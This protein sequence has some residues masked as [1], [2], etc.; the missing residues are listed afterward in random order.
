MDGVRGFGRGLRGFWED[1]T[2][3]TDGWLNTGVSTEKFCPPVHMCIHVGRGHFY[4][5][6]YFNKQVDLK[7]N[8]C[9]ALAIVSSGDY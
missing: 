3:S 7:N 5:C 8:P 9:T 6:I 1:G 2:L 4:T